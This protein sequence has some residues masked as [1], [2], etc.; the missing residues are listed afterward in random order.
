MTAQIAQLI[1]GSDSAELVRDRIATILLEEQANQQVLAPPQDPRLWALRIFTEAS[2]PWEQFQA[3]PAQ[4]DATPLVNVQLD[5]I[6]P[7]ISGSNIVERQK[8]VGTYN[9]DVYGYGVSAAAGG[10]HVPGDQ[11]A[12]LEVYRAARLVRRILMSS[13]YT[14]L[15]TDLRGTVWKRWV[16]S[17]QVFKPS[18][19]RRPV[20]HV[21]GAR[22][23][24]EVTFNEFSPQIHAQILDTIAISVTRTGS[25]ELLFNETIQIP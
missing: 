8:V 1:T 11:K 21:M 17:I 6:E 4:L 15:G 23:V 16:S 18:E 3:E 13:F 7:D 10:G 20:E 22:V 12:A 9:I 24:F 25:G 2:N 5:K 14:Y 19:D